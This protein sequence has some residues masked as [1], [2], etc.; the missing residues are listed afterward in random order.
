M[1]QDKSQSQLPLA[2]VKGSWEERIV[3]VARLLGNDDPT[4]LAAS[5]ALIDRLSRI[6]AAQRAAADHRL[7]RAL[8][9]A[10][11]N[12]ARHLAAAE[13]Y[14]AAA[15]TLWDG[16]RVI[17]GEIAR[18][19]ELTALRYLICGG[20]TAVPLEA[21]ELLAAAGDI[22]DWAELFSAAVQSGDYAAGRRSLEQAER[23]VNHT[24]QAALDT[25][26]ARRDQAILAN[27][28]ARFAVD[29][30]NFREAVAWYEHAMA[31]DDYYRQNPSNLYVSLVN[32]G[33]F[34]EAEGLLKAEDNP[35]LANFWRG[36]IEYRSGRLEPAS[37]YWL[38]VTRSEPSVTTPRGTLESVLSYYYLGD[39]SG[40][41]LSRMLN[42]LKMTQDSWGTFYLAGLGWA[43]RDD[44]PTAKEDMLLAVKLFR[45]NGS[46]RLLPS[47]TWLH[48]Q[49]LLD[50][51]KC[52]SLKEFFKHA[53]L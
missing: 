38:K 18:E 39:R 41:G 20:N 27:M 25:P 34:I 1:N 23:W 43:M 45:A 4:A 47:D 42:L 32:K 19:M 7:N 5:Q 8:I 35:V 37:R 50:A 3:R 53:T 49:D 48:C 46:G 17:E 31:L 14:E 13:E 52:D 29:Q 51:E 12:Q 28:K 21:L 6:P 22:D 26:A 24:H 36:L 16:A 30:N 40:K 11:Q 15:T 9:T 2:Q 10:L 44:M 33:A